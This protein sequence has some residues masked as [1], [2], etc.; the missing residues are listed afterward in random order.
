MDGSFDLLLFLLVWGALSQVGPVS[1]V[2][3]CFVGGVG[4]V[5]KIQV[6][7]K[8]KNKEVNAAGWLVGWLADL[9]SFMFCLL[10]DGSR[11]T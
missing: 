8:T 4:V 6:D 11:A 3:S 5:C 1:L 7:G 2:G 10:L 9:E